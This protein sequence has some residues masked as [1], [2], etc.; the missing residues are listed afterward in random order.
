MTIIQGFVK[1]GTLEFIGRS[2]AA[3][4]VRPELER[5]MGEPFMNENQALVECDAACFFVSDILKEVGLSRLARGC[6]DADLAV[7]D[8]GEQ[9]GIRIA[10]VPDATEI[11]E[12]VY[13]PGPSGTQQRFETRGSLD[14]PIAVMKHMLSQPNIEFAVWDMSIAELKRLE[15]LS[16]TFVGG[17][18]GSVN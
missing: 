7:T 8:R 2:A 13:I 18:I 3:T 1:A 15:K 6:R 10:F 14:A 11:M 16:Q 12:A 5:Q 17:Q 4:L 9:R